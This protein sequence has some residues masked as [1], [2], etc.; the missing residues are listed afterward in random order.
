MRRELDPR[1]A[2]QARGGTF[3]ANPGC[4]QALS[5]HGAEPALVEPPGAEAVGHRDLEGAELGLSLG[6]KA[7]QPGPQ[8]PLPLCPR[9][10]PSA[11]LATCLTAIHPSVLPSTINR[12]LC[13]PQPLGAPKGSCWGLPCMLTSPFPVQDQLRA[14]WAVI[15]D[16]PLCSSGPSWSCPGLIQLHRC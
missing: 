5:A 2:R 9:E 12:M 8:A 11:A 16:S 3:A 15:S 6:P 7:W 4:L 10:L 1:G 14:A 13:V